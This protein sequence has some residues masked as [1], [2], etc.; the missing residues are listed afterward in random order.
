MGERGLVKVSFYGEQ[1]EC[2][3]D[4]RG[5]KVSLR[6]LCD[7]IGVDFAA[8]LEKLRARSWA[9]V[10]QCPT[11]AEDGK[12]RE[13]ITIDLD[14][15]PMWLATIDA[16]RVAEHVRPKLE[17][18]Q[19]ECAKALRDYWFNGKAERGTSEAG[20]GLAKMR[21]EAMALNARVRAGKALTAALDALNRV[22]PLARE[23]IAAGHAKAAELIAGERMAFLNP[24]DHPDWAASEDI[25]R[26]V[27]ESFSPSVVGR[28]SA[29]IG[30]KVRQD[31]LVR[32]VTQL[33]ER[34]ATRECWQYRAEAR[35]KLIEACKRWHDEEFPSLAALAASYTVN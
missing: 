12:R 7:N 2:V 26:E 29:L 19:R 32:V 9:T 23:C 10:G 17:L 4:A 31:G 11:V 5:V 21:A 16:E 6:R 22:V 25:A 1:I 34:G 15:V 33:D 35:T 28:I 14:S 8:Q 27:D 24:P 3:R 30:L 18:Y 20:E 13:M